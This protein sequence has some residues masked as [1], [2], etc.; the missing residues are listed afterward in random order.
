[1]GVSRRAL[2]DSAEPHQHQPQVTGRWKH[3]GISGEDPCV[4]AGDQEQE[5]ST[6]SFKCSPAQP[7]PPKQTADTCSMSQDEPNSAAKTQENAEGA[8][9]CKEVCGAVTPVPHLPIT[10]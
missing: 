7:V 8:M 10:Q 9:S 5:F 2:P 1:D 4:G 6:G 3:T